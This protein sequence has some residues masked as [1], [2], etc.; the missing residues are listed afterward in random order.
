M[1]TAKCRPTAWRPSPLGLP[2]IRNRPT[3]V[4]AWRAQAEAIRARYGAIANEPVP[5]RL[6]LDQLMLQ[7]RSSG[8]SWAA[9]AAVA[10]I[11][12]H[13]RR[14]RRL[15]GAWGFGRRTSRLRDT[16]RRS[17]R[18][19]QALCRRGPSSG[20][21]AGQRTRAHDAVAVEAARLSAQRTGI[22][23]R[24]GLKLVGGRL[25]P[26][27]TG[28]AAFYMYESHVGRALHHL[29]RKVGVAGDARCATSDETQ[30][31]RVLL[32]RR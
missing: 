17:A 23:N 18:R 32:G 15:D 19:L 12:L 13:G 1:S 10:L 20:R 28:A 25:L 6:K 24:L 26:G 3:L 22:C 21:S 9:L 29:L 7:D 2:R 8:R 5:D 27:P 4:A 14:R 11:A 31:S 16:H 30:R